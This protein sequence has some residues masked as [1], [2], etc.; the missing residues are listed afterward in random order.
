MTNDQ[1]TQETEVSA[2]ESGR[3]KTP[4]IEHAATESE[5]S[6]AQMAPE[7]PML[8]GQADGAEQS[9]QHAYAQWGAIAAGAAAGAVVSLIVQGA[10]ILFP[11]G[12]DNASAVE[13]RVARL[14]SSIA[15]L[16]AAPDG[17]SSTHLSTI[18]ADLKALTDKLATLAQRNDNAVAASTEARQR[19]VTTAGALAELRQKVMSVAADGAA[20]DESVQAE[21]KSLTNRVSAIETAEKAITAEITKR[22][23]AQDRDRSG[24][25]ATAA[26]A[27][28]IAVEE[29]QPF[30]GELAVARVLAP[31]PKQLATL[32]PFAMSG[33]PT[34]AALA[35]DLAS[36]MAALYAAAAT[37]SRESSFLEKLQANAE[38]LVRIRRTD[39]GAG[40]DPGAVL[41]R[42]EIKAA[43]GDV[44]GSLAELAALP[45]DIRAPAAAWMEKA[46]G[47]S[48]AL[49]ASRRLADEALA[50]LSK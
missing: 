50:E 17:V 19:V 32:E 40:S 9:R 36:L 11:R 45:P 46:R 15:G 39:E 10:A 22:T 18:E 1:P 37:R 14:E 2:S 21:L 42:I 49:A 23:Q 12:S 41:G 26:T 8:E 3:E 25:F 33:V 4:V 48:A 29:G 6:P 43:K 13:A 35:R 28:R 34:S 44:A 16:R 31:D 20:R 47:H 27:L 38:K 7:Q 5:A 30:A 24:R